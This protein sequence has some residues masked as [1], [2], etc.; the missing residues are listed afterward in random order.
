[1]NPPCKK[2]AHSVPRDAGD[3]VFVLRARCLDSWGLGLVGTAVKNDSDIRPRGNA[4]GKGKPQIEKVYP[5]RATHLPPAG[6]LVVPLFVDTVAYLEVAAEIYWHRE[7]AVCSEGWLSWLASWLAVW[8]AG[9]A[10]NAWGI[11]DLKG[12]LVLETSRSILMR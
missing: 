7:P 8:H 12:T 1:M 11:G 5:R 4:N 2:K 9:V 6:W 10:S 3:D